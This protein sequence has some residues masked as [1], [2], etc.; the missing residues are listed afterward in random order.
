VRTLSQNNV[1]ANY[2]WSDFDE[3]QLTAGGVPPAT[4]IPVRSSWKYLDDGSNQGTAWSE[5]SYND[6]G[7]SNGI[8]QLGF[9]DGD[10]NTIIRSNRTD[11]SRIITYYF[12]KN[13]TLN[14]PTSFTNLIVRLLRDDGA[15]AYLNGAEIFRSN[16]TNTPI[17]YTTL[18]LTSVP[19]ED[20]TIK[21]YDTNVNPGLLLAGNNV[22]AVE[23][24]QNSTGSSDLS[25]DLE[26]FGA[27][28]FIGNTAPTALITSPQNGAEFSAG[29]DIEASVEATDNDDEVALVEFFVDGA[30]ISQTTDAPFSLIWSNAPAGYHV[31]TARAIDSRGA[32]GLSAA[33]S[34]NVGMATLV[35]TGAVWRFLDD[36]SDQQNAWR[37]ILFNDSSW[38]FGPAELGYG[39]AAPPDSRPE[40][41]VVG[42]GPVDTNKYITTYFR[43]S[44]FVPDAT[45]FTNLTL[46]LL[47]DD[48]AIVFLNDRE[49][50]RSNMPT[51]AVNY[52][53]PAFG[54]V[55]GVDETTYFST[56]VNPALLQ[57]GTNLLA[58]EIHQING[59]SSD[60][61]FDLQLVGATTP[62]SPR[63]EISRS[64]SSYVLY[65]P[66]A[67][68][69]F[70][71]FAAN[72]L[73]PPIDWQPVTTNAI[74]D[75][76][77]KMISV[78]TNSASRFYRLSNR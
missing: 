65:W 58:V 70:H 24:H 38:A 37:T 41:T 3:T 35:N 66:S 76:S 2:Q 62:L 54:G 28:N 6:A 26:L 73:S 40:A 22:L 57:T 36:G 74:D 71:L 21:F 77:R 72:S 19:A 11:S 23:V 32:S 45:Y 30:K 8:A 49:V 51:G 55:S 14:N 52:L 1:G 16:M 53:T 75:G 42:Y 29:T 50:F 61:S 67:A 15:V 59:S 5:L 78:A 60:I 39:D 34:I 63:L 46:R 69:G 27:T 56:N 68:V 44:W 64:G 7:W 9:G 17:D 18:A 43:R 47:R 25:F 12:R 4:L 48:G 31:M 33:V 20:E 13:F 10:E